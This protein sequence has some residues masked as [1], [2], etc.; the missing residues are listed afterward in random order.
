MGGVIVAPEPVK[1]MPK[2]EGKEAMLPAPATIVVSLPAEAKLS[3][4]D[5]ATTSTSAL[6]TFVSPELPAGRDF[7]YTLKAE[8]QHEGKPA[9]VTKV[10]GVRAG[11]ETRVTISAA[12]LATGIASR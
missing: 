3:I 12:D 4:D 11:L 1:P 10:V 7:N 2:P 5:A 6:R 9:V 8:F